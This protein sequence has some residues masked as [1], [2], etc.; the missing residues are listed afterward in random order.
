MMVS[1]ITP[2]YNCANYI[3][4]TIS[5]VLS[6][7]YSEWE[8][9]IVDDCST[10]NSV[11]VIKSH[12]EKDSRI[13]LIQLNENSG[14]AIARN[15]AIEAA[16]GRYIAFLDSDD[17]WE[18]EK[19]ATQISFMQKN[20]IAFSF[21]AYHKVDEQGVNI[22]KV[23]VPEKVTYQK[24][25]KCCVIGCLTA[26][27]DTQ[28]LGKVYMPLIRKRQDFG[29]WLRIL[30]KCDSAYGLNIPLAKYRIRKDS[31]SSN[32][33][34]AAQYNWK[35]YREVEKLSLFKSVYYFSHYAI[36][37]VLRSRSKKY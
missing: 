14:A 5:S 31:I 4:E 37:G 10:D 19:L 12:I 24:L 8:M 27:Y 18:P 16:Q 23:D 33:L 21:S 7:T 32:K 30:K 6:Q 26:I 35:L 22:G 15:T 29:L 3:F 13:K 11:S 25:L 34:K 36:N 20:D 17:L 1:I 28:K 2:S 9:I